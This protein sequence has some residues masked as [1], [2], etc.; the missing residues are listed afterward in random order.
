MTWI[1]WRNAQYQKFLGVCISVINAYAILVAVSQARLTRPFSFCLPLGAPR[2]MMFFS[3]RKQDVGPSRIF[4]S[5]SVYNREGLPPQLMSHCWKVSF[6]DSW[7]RF[8]KG[9]I[10]EYRVA[11]STKV[12]QYKAPLQMDLQSPKPMLQWTTSKNFSG[13]STGVL[14][15]RAFFILAIWPSSKKLSEGLIKEKLGWHT[16]YKTSQFLNDQKPKYL[17]NCWTLNC[18]DEGA[19]LDILSLDNKVGWFGGIEEEEILV[20]V[21][22]GSR[23]FKR[24]G[25]MQPFFSSCFVTKFKIS[26]ICLVERGEEVVVRV[27]S[28]LWETV[29]GSDSKG[30]SSSSS[31]IIGSDVDVS[32][33]CVDKTGRL[34]GWVG[35]NRNSKSRIN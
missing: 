13:R 25:E 17:E 26:W 29:C 31:G 21:L 5:K 33:T 10:Q 20:G 16:S 34:E 35:M 7:W 8:F 1:D 22:F 15:E 19:V 14:F 18:I 30:I 27:L 24:A 4:G 2:R 11:R 9:Y 12:R 23:C 3:Q 6:R 28:S 32:C